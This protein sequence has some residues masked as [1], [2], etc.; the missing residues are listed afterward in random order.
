M[1][2]IR[3]ASKDDLKAVASAASER[4]ATKSVA[5]SSANGLMS[6]TDKAKLDYVTTAFATCGT[7]AGTAAKAATLDASVKGFKLVVGATAYVKFTNTNTFAAT[8]DSPVTLNVGGTG[9]KRIYYGASDSNTGTAT[10]P[11]GRAG[12]V[13]TYV[14]DGTNWVWAGSSNDNNT[15]YSALSQADATA[16]T[17][18]TARLITAKVLNDTIA[19]KGYT[20]NTGTVTSVSAGVGL[21][22]GPVT[23]TG[24]IKAKLKSETAHTAS[25]ATPTDASGR[26]YPVGV[27][28]DGYLSANVPWTDTTALGSMTG[29]LGVA[30]GGTGATTLGAGVVYHSASGTGALSIATAANIVSAIGDSAVARATADASGNDIADTYARKADIASTYR[31]KGSV[32]SASGLPSSGQAVGDVYNIE[33]ASAYGAAGANVAW[34]GTAW[35]SLG[36]IFSVAAITNAEIDAIV[37]S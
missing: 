24:T 8:A 34:N 9:A 16:G 13:N 36:E 19:G 27:D 33:T 17:S 23:T 25:S 29:T 32:A 15:T 1:A 30:H 7:A 31:Y 3:F 35:D 2:D 6:S 10:V 28:K 22:G 20:S 4:Y 37:A 12:Y 11:Y 14:Y 18:T 26:Q 5:T 21:A